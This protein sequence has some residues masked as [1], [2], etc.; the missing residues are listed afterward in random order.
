MDNKQNCSYLVKLNLSLSSSTPQYL[1]YA[2]QYMQVPR[3]QPPWLQG[4]N[5]PSRS[6]VSPG[7]HSQLWPAPAEESVYQPLAAQT[8]L[9]SCR[10]TTGKKRPNLESKIAWKWH[11]T[12]I[13]GKHNRLGTQT[14]GTA[15]DML[16]LYRSHCRWLV[17]NLE[18]RSVSNCAENALLLSMYL[19]I[20]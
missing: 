8:Q 20:I 5:L 6:P 9:P 16:S 4:Q 19:E 17:T 7:H 3:L 11:K 13:E 18:A 12:G 15:W 1:H 14:V 2:L 10:H